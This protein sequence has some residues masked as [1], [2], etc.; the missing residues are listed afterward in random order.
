MLHY[1]ILNSYFW[2][3]KESDDSPDSEGWAFVGYWN[4][5]RMQV[6][7]GQ[8]K[9]ARNYVLQQEIGNG[10]YEDSFM[11]IA[12][13]YRTD[14]VAVYFRDDAEGSHEETF[15]QWLRGVY[16]GAQ[17]EI[18]TVAPPM[19]KN[20]RAGRPRVLTE[21]AIREIEQQMAKGVSTQIIADLSG[22]SVSTI[23]R[24]KK[25]NLEKSK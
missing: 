2:M 12:R 10:Q 5:K 8:A 20:H 14:Q 24:A 19:V 22:T 13:Q 7:K 11:I 9:Y 18:T 21:E 6:S 1:W 25:K 15:T 4:D 3:Y 17:P 16:P 23:R